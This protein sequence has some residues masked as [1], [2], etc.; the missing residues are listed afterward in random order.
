MDIT[1]PEVDE[2]QALRKSENRLFPDYNVLAM[3]Q[4]AMVIES[5][6]A[7]AEDFIVKPFQAERVIEAVKSSW[8]MIP[9]KWEGIR[10]DVGHTESHTIPD[11]ILLPSFLAYVTAR[12][13]GQKQV[14]SMKAKHKRVGDRDAQYG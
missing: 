7:G 10:W 6:Q 13:I 1:M 5:I 14:G 11:R 2:V 12:Y 9:V 3:G 4:Q 8:L